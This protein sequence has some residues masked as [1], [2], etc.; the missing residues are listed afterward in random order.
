MNC[1]ELRDHYEL[2]ALG[3][4]EDPERDEIRA[5]LDRGCEVCMAEMKRAREMA[6][7]LGGCSAPAAPSPKLRRRILASVG[8]EHRGFGWTPLLAGSTIMCLAAAFYF[9]G[10]EWDFSRQVRRLTEESRA[11]IIELTRLNEA[12]ALMN[13]AD[14]TVTSFGE[15]KPTPKGKL[16]YNPSMGALLIASNLPQAPAGKTYELWLIPKAKGA[17]PARA[18]MFQSQSDGTVMHMI[19]GPIDATTTAALAVTM[20]VDTGVDAPTGSILIF[21]P[22]APALQ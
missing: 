5:H 12:F 22:L 11:Q 19:R 18:G 6:A 9:G 10:R 7:L 13:G 20:E 4:A 21:A 17:N 2:Y 8:A 3:L 1:T 16:F 14:T 15:K